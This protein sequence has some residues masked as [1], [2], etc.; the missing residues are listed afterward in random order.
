MSSIE[1]GC[2]SAYCK[3]C[4]AFRDGH[5][6]GCRLGYESGQRDINRAKC[7]IK[8]CCMREKHLQTCTEC[9]DYSSCTI[10]QNWYEKAGSKYHRYKTSAEFIRE[11]GYDRFVEIADKWKDSRGKLPV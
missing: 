2:C 1:I 7:R 9:D 8:V 10:L 11:H 4:R 5:Y 6:R 3:T